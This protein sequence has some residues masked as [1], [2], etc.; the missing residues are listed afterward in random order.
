[1]ESIQVINDRITFFGSPTLIEIMEQ[2]TVLFT[3]LLHSVKLH[4]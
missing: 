2:M 3:E 4:F 1:M